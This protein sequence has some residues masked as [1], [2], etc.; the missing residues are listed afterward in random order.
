MIMTKNGSLMPSVFCGSAGHVIKLVLT[1]TKALEEMERKKM[2]RIKSL[3]CSR[4]HDGAH[5]LV[6]MISSTL[7]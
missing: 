2:I 3:E 6:P 4:N 5:T 7:L 1:W